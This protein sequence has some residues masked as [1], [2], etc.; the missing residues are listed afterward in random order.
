MGVTPLSNWIRASRSGCKTVLNR[1]FEKI[2]LHVMALLL[3]V[4]A[5]K[6]TDAVDE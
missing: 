2:V 4:I 6:G 5:N 1:Q 3:K